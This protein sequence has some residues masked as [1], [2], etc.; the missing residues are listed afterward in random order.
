MKTV[1]IE[2]SLTYDSELMHGNDESAIEWFN[3]S[4]LGSELYLFSNE[5]GDEIG[6]ITDLIID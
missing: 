5:I 1:K 6:K 4:V 3:E 2:A